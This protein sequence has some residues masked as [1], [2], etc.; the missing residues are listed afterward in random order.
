[1]QWAEEGP[2]IVEGW[3]DS[4]YQHLELI[5]SRLRLEMEIGFNIE[6]T[7]Y[8]LRPLQELVHCLW[9]W[10]YQNPKPKIWWYSSLEV[11]TASTFGCLRGL[12]N[13][14]VSEIWY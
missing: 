6:V 10:L 3:K 1:M 13:K 8:N 12:R 4:A 14:S 2:R 11:V 7:C 5:S 9:F